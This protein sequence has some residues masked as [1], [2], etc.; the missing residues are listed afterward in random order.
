[1]HAVIFLTCTQLYYEDYKKIRLISTQIHVLYC[2]VVTIWFFKVD[3]NRCKFACFELVGVPNTLTR[4]DRALIPLGNAVYQATI[5]RNQKLQ[6]AWRFRDSH[7]LGCGPLVKVVCLH[8]RRPR[9]RIHQGCPNR[10]ERGSGWKCC[11]RRFTNRECA[12]QKR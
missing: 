2:V 6:D 1:M 7:H 10:R 12:L 8:Q 5:C 4:Y 9:Q 3:E 11:R